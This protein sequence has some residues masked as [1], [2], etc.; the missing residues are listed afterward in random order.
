MFDSDRH[1]GDAPMTCELLRNLVDAGTLTVA[2]IADRW[3]IEKHSVYPYLTDREM[4]AGQLR[5]LFRTARD[6][7]IQSEI[8]NYLMAGTGWTPVYIDA[9]LDIDGDGDVDGDD[10]IAHAIGALND[11]AQFLSQV[12]AG[13]QCPDVAQLSKLKAGVFQ[14]VVSADR[15]VHRIAEIKARRRKARPV[16]IH[17]TRSAS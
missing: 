10:A 15:C 2:E 6:P 12:Q 14:G 9:E 3:N 17:P 5:T 8:C 13:G 1:Y 11:L 4:R 16:S 7:R